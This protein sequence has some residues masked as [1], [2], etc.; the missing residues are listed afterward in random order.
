MVNVDNEDPAFVP[1]L[2]GNTLL[3]AE[4]F[5]SD[6]GLC[7][8]DTIILSLSSTNLIILADSNYDKLKLICYKIDIEPPLRFE[9]KKF[10]IL[11][12]DYGQPICFA[13]AL[14]G[15][16]KSCDAIQFMFPGSQ[17]FFSVIQLMA[18]GSEIKIFRLIPDEASSVDK[19]LLQSGQ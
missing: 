11:Q 14:C 2:A 19:N 12:S 6:D 4:A 17:G 10:R 7:F 15:A 9:G 1:K 5:M 8:M 16:D 3:C 18:I 13:W